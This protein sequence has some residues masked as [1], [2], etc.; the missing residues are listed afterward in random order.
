VTLKVQLVMFC[1]K[2]TYLYNWLCVLLVCFILGYMGWSLAL[3]E[4][5]E[6]FEALHTTHGSRVG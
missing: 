5:C 3:T 4:A 6:M 2:K 1:C